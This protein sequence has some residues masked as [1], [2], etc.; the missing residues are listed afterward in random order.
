MSDGFRF[1]DW[2]EGWECVRC[3]KE[4]ERDGGSD[5]NAVDEGLLQVLLVGDGQVTQVREDAGGEKRGCVHVRLF[6][7]AR[8]V[9][10]MMEAS[11]VC[12]H[13]LRAV[14]VCLRADGIL[15][16]RL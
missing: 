12:V 6:G 11:F 10:Q 2:G 9:E 16:E 8:A 5:C 13:G 1:R 7:R 4:E 15:V 3:E 14:S